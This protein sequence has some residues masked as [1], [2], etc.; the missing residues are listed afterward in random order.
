MFIR[1]MFSTA[2]IAEQGVLHNEVSPLV[3]AGTLKVILAKVFAT[4]SAENLRQAQAPI[5]NGPPRAG[6]L[7]GGTDLRQSARLL[8]EISP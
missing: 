3:D 5:E 8:L 7:K 6:S 2:E 4:I 1:S